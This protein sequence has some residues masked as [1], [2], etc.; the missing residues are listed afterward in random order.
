MSSLFTSP[1]S[2]QQLKSQIQNEHQ[3]QWFLSIL[4]KQVSSVQICDVYVTWVKSCNSKGESKIACYVFHVSDINKD[5]VRNEVNEPI[6][7]VACSITIPCQNVIKNNMNKLL[8]LSRRVRGGQIQ[9]H[10]RAA[11]AS[12]YSEKSEVMCFTATCCWRRPVIQCL[13]QT[14][15]V[16]VFKGPCNLQAHP[17]SL[18]LW[19][20]VSVTSRLTQFPCVGH[21]TDTAVLPLHGLDHVVEASCCLMIVSQSFQGLDDIL[22]RERG[23][24]ASTGAKTASRVASSTKMQRKLLPHQSWLQTSLHFGSQRKRQE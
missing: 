7:F 10:L 4:F 22:R 1:V 12:L 13:G 11:A 24:G 20:S 9:S 8:Y 18:A 21:C 19:P 2:G 23:E 3:V 5:Q 6:V 16:A 14:P 17:A 15:P